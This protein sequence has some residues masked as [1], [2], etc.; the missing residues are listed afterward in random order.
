[1]KI[2]ISGASGF[3]GTRLLE[4][5]AAAGHQLHV[6]S[7]R[8][9]APPPS[10]ANLSVWDPIAGEPASQDLR[11]QDAV[12]HLA[13]ENV[14]QRWTAEARRRILESRVNGT[15]NLVA[16]LARL[17]RRPAT[18]ICASATGYYGPRGDEIL[19]ESAAPGT[20][21]L[22]EVCAAW[23]RE[24]QAA[25]SLGMRVVRMRIGLVLD[26]RGGALQRML[27]PFRMGVG[28]RLGDGRQWMSWIHLDDLAALFRFAL[29]QPLEGPVNG[30]APE[31]VTNAEFT[32]ALAG[33]LRRPAFFPLPAIALR[34]LFGEMAAMLLT[35]QRVVPR[36]AYA[37]GFTFRFP[38]LDA[39]LADLLKRRV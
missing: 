26:P 12:I 24:A 14:G 27:P 5:L 11:D 20:G 13:G 17:S 19:D 16:A 18:L 29:E 22:A 4:T 39:A 10:A 3:I 36:A 6:F 1:M 25:G 35:G 28:G 31:P 32:R 8:T 37:A 21:F 23:E 34:A 15:R 30:V 7:R 33:A 2:A 38:R 9:G